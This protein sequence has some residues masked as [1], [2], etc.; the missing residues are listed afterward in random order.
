MG[1]PI[2][3]R[4]SARQRRSMSCAS[5]KQLSAFA[6]RMADSLLRQFVS[7]EEITELE[8]RSVF[9]I[10]T[11]HRVLLDARCPLLADGACL[12]LCRIGGAHQLAVI[13]DGVFLLQRYH[14]DRTARHEVGQRL[15]ERTMHV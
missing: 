8:T 2:C 13:G 5:G 3:P 12:S 15:E 14:D 10:G 4:G 1:P 11:V 6:R 9:A 7:G